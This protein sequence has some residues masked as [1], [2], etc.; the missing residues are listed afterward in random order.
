MWRSGMGSPTAAGRRL[1]PAGWWFGPRRNARRND[2]LARARRVGLREY[3]ALAQRHVREFGNKVA[4]RRGPPSEALVGS[5][6]VQSLADP[7][8]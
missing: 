1:S 7:E 8:Q 3:G 5:S 4:P 2:R 6:N